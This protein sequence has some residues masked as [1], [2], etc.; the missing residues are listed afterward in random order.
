MPGMAK[1]RISKI[2]YDT[3]T[4]TLSDVVDK[5]VMLND[6]APVVF[7]TDGLEGRDLKLIRGLCIEGDGIDENGMFI[8]PRRVD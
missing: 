7:S 3:K 5:S 8:N 2:D 1:L 4:I 6:D